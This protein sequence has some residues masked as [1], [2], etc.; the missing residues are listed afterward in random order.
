MMLPMNP[1]SCRASISRT[2]L[3]AIFFA[4]FFISSALSKTWDS[5]GAAQAY[6]EAGEKRSQISGSTQPALS[7]YLEC[8]KAYRRVHIKDPHSRH[9]PEAIYAEAL[10]YQEMGDR[11]SSLDF[12]KTAAKRFQLLVKHYPG[13]SNCPDALLRMGHIFE[14]NIGDEIAAQ[15]AFQVLKSN[16]KYS[17]AARQISVKES[18]AKA[19]APAPVIPAPLKAS[20]T[21]SPAVFESIRH[22]TTE[23]YTRVTIQLDSSTQFIKERLSKPERLYFD[24]PDTRFGKDQKAQTIPV[25]DAR[26]QQIRISAKSQET[27]RIVLDLA[28]KAD[29]SISE[30]STPFRIVVDLFAKEDSAARLKKPAAQA[31]APLAAAVPSVKAGAARPKAPPRAIT[32]LSPSQAGTGPT[33]RATIPRENVKPEAVPETKSVAVQNEPALPESDSSA[34]QADPVLDAKVTLPLS[35]IEKQNISAK[36]SQEPENRKEEAAKAALETKTLPP[37]SGPKAAVPTSQGARTLTRMLGLKIGRIVIDPGHGGHDLG[38]VGPGGLYEKDLVLSIARELQTL[39]IKNVGAEVILTR[40]ED[41]FLSLEERSAMA[42]QYRADLFISIHANSSRHRSISGVETYYLDFAK[43]SAER[44]IA[45]RENASASSSLHELEDLVKKIAQADR[46]SESRELAFMVQKSLFAGSKKVI[47]STQN[48]G[49]RSAP[50]IVLIGANMPSILVEVAFISNPRVEKI[51]KSE[52]NKD[53]VV[54]ALYSGIE[55]Y[56]KT[57]GSELVQNRTTIK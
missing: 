29:Y 19:P 22:Q 30:L 1:V 2:I 33:A 4:S 34:I 35:V 27:I 40:N 21:P 14:R 46:S 57:L 25:E 3:C 37:Q 50:F 17:A 18:P 48:R 41:V 16:Y 32:E 15:D 7:L 45:A 39:L 38:T 31:S 23:K 42:N 28:G 54:K 13:N 47:P 6:Q 53:H 51:L 9:S 12:Y 36:S 55:D 24:L 10:L 56:M 11:F 5:V 44:E 20:K 43:T 26:L 52:A 8:A 49:V